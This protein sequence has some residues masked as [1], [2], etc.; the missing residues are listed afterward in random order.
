MLIH[1]DLAD[2]YQVE[3]KALKRAVRRNRDRFPADFLLELTLEEAS[4]LR[5]QFGT[6]KKAIL[7]SFGKI[8]VSIDEVSD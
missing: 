5:S 7:T 8:Y 3:A 2:L 1:A 6:L 4:A